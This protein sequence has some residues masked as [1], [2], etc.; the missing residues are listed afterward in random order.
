MKAQH[1]HDRIT[2]LEEI[3]GQDQSL[4]GRLRDA[5]QLEPIHAQILGMLYKRDFVTRD[6]L[7]TVLYEG[8]PESEWPEEKI[9]DVQMCKLR[10]HLKKR[11][12][13]II[14]ATKWGQGWVLSQDSRSAIKAKLGP[15]PDAGAL[16]VAPDAPKLSPASSVALQP[17]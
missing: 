17:A 1:L 6:G 15:R 8:R 4:T 7:Y 10:K 2:A 16:P 9:L 13:K 11:G 14:I 5:Y 3:L 12:E